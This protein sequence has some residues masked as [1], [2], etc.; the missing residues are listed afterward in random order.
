[1]LHTNSVELQFPDMSA[2]WKFAQKISSKSIEINTSNKKLICNCT[3]AEVTDAINNY[4]AQL[5]HVK[6]IQFQ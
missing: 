1:M 4:G 3:D 6:H 2:L 5:L